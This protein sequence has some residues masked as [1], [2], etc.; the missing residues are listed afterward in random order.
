VPGSDAHMSKTRSSSSPS[1]VCAAATCAG[2]LA[3]S[4]MQGAPL[5]NGAE[6]VPA[7]A[8]ALYYGSSQPGLWEL[9]PEQRAAIG[10]LESSD[11]THMCTATMVGARW[12]L[13]AAHC[14][15]GN[16][17]RFRIPSQQTQR[18]RICSQVE[19]PELDVKL[20]ELDVEDGREPC[21]EPI[22]LWQSAIDTSWEGTS[23][24]MAG[25]GLTEEGTTGELRF[26]EEPVVDVKAT[27][28]RV[29][30]MGR[31][32]ACL[33]DSGGPLLVRDAAATLRIAGVLDRGSESCVS[34]DVYVRADKFVDWARATLA[35]VT[36]MS[37]DRL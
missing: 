21:A 36:R 1:V 5:E 8:A 32:G 11:G 15:S 28:L 10:A 18:W 37:C 23:V 22:G 26:A 3:T 16:D 35:D 13:T 17:L 4:C 7:K 25:L 12:V 33:G 20:L 14:A 9:S 31:T 6:C 34:A 24:V 30:G 29:D 2:L 27:E 19:H